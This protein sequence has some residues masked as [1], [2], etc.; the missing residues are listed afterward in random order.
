[1]T[2]SRSAM[3]FVGAGKMGGALIR[4]L[5]PTVSI[6]Y[7]DPAV[8]ML[9]G[10]VRLERVEAAAAVAP[11]EAVVLATKPAL[12][13]EMTRT[14]DR[15]LPA[16]VPFVSIAA[17]IPLARLG[18]CSGPVRPIVRL[19]PNLPAQVGHGALVFAREAGLD[20]RIAA[21]L[22]RI[23]APAGRSFWLTGDRLFDAVTALSGSG[24][25][26]FFRVAEAMARG[27]E[28]LGLPGELALA[29]AQAT[30]AGAG[31][32]CG[33]PSTT[34]A[35]LRAAVTSPNGTTHAALEALEQGGLEALVRRA[36]QAAAQ[37]SIDL[38][39]A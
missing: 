33:Q 6:H 15:I 14:L 2:E 31:A 27:G 26:Y 8:P 19:M 36:M 28:A 3:L 21:D 29:M 23:F 5:S 12:V 39:R 35:G 7:V 25:A 18:S 38:S 17:G 4:A 13:V 34:L 11:L 10:A 9:R 24:P 16:A 20:D 37:R 30:L 22:E 32:L 1:M